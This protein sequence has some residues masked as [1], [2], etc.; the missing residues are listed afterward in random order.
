MMAKKGGKVREDN[1]LLSVKPVHLLQPC[2]GSGISIALHLLQLRQSVLL[3]HAPRMF[4]LLMRRCI[5]A[6]HQR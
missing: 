1:E 4:T 6:I 3:P 5:K 2:T